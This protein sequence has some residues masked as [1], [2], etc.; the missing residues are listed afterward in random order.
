M[1]ASR[2]ALGLSTGGVFKPISFA[3]RPGLPSLRSA[4][5]GWKQPAVSAA[6]AATAMSRTAIRVLTNDIHDPHG[7]NDYLAHGLAAESEFYRIERQN[8]SLNF[9]ILGDPWHGNITPF[10]AVDLDHQRH[11]VFD[12][13]IAFDLGPVGLRNQ[14]G[15]PQDLPALLGQM[16]HHRRE[17]L[18]KDGPGFPNRP[19]G[20][21]GRLAV[22]P[23]Y[24]GQRVGEFPDMG[25]ADI[26]MQ[27][28]DPGRHLVQRAMAGLAQAERIG[29]ERGRPV[30]GSRPG[31]LG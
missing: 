23:Q 30:G 21:G 27:P 6:R 2:E 5:I 22:L 12:Q 17:K 26:E 29:A 18:N 10:L 14:P 13:Q 19:G 11:S 1:R 20:V 24:F 25:P 15:L 4:Y 9:R 16:R 28:F 8:G 7:N 3:R 31:N